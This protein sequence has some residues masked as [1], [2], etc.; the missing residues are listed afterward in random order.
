MVVFW[1][2]SGHQPKRCDVHSP[3]SNAW[4]FPHAKE[5][6]YIGLIS[7]LCEKNKK[8]LVNLDLAATSCRLLSEYFAPCKLKIRHTPKNFTASLKFTK[9]DPYRILK[10]KIIKLPLKK[11]LAEIVWH[12]KV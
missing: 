7:Q 1:W 4:I 12:E 2:P 11:K 8:R 3:D 9:N 10:N 6:R 5:I